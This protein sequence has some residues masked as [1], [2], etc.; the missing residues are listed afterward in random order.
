MKVKELIEELSKH[1][2]DKEVIFAGDLEEQF[3]SD[4]KRELVFKNLPFLYIKENEHIVAIGVEA[5][6]AEIIHNTINSIWMGGVE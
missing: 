2:Q 1:N 4:F 6:Y 3:T 5:D